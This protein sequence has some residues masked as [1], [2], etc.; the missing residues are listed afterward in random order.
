M[1]SQ[2]NRPGR[3]A[4][5]ERQPHRLWSL[6]DMLELKAASFFEVTDRL[7]GTAAYIGAHEE[8]KESVFHSGRV[9]EAPDR[10]FAAGRLGGLPEHLDI[11]G[12]RITALTAQEANEY[13]LRA[14]ATWGGFKER[15]DEIRNTLKRELTL[16]KVFSVEPAKHEYFVPSRPLFGGE[17]DSKFRGASYDLDEAAKCLALGRPT[18]CVFHLMR[19][20]ESGVRAVAR[21]LKIDDPVK[22]AERNW[23]FVLG[24]VWK[25]IEKRWPNAAARASGDGLLFESLHASLDAVKNPWRNETMHAG[26][27]YT[28]DEAEH[29]FVAVKGFMKKLAERCDEEGLPLA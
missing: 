23:G 25:G 3:A 19:V 29:V 5:S 10:A 28:D 14:G 6:W 1:I 7:S 4:L 9:L 26:T 20:M 16:A 18:A 22:P 21:C 8:R 24:E 2:F 27:K 15:L 13:I 12:A 17:F 11:L